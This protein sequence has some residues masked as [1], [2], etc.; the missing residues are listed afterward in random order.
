MPKIRTLKTAAKRFK[1]TATGK[2]KR[3]HSYATHLK[4][5]KPASRKRKLRRAAMVS[6]ADTPKLRRMMPY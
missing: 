2:F 4:V 5:G 3:G 6:K 1:K